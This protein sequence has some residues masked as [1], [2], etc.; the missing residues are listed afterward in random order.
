MGRTR[1]A[2]PQIVVTGSTELRQVWPEETTEIDVPS[3][4]IGT[5]E[6]VFELL[7]AADGQA[8]DAYAWRHASDA[9][10]VL[11]L[12]HYSVHDVLAVAIDLPGELAPGRVLQALHAIDLDLSLLAS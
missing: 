11:A 7:A 4:L 5:P 2:E 12:T 9:G 8:V 1:K 3:G 6:A 10:A